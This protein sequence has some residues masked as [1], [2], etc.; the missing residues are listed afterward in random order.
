VGNWRKSTHSDANG[1]DCVEVASTDLI[2]VR[3][4][5]DRRGAVV[6]VTAETWR[7]F[8]SLLKQGGSGCQETA[9]V[10]K[11]TFFCRDLPHR[12]DGRFLIASDPNSGSQDARRHIP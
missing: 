12:F 1:G 4:T 3:D 5:T 8:T 9:L 7:S 11:P 2:M 6:S 10:R